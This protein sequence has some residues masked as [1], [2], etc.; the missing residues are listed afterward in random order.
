MNYVYVDNDIDMPKYIKGS[1]FNQECDFCFHV[2][3][4][5]IM[6]ICTKK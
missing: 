2:N 5:V 6:Y 4:S 3:V 1:I